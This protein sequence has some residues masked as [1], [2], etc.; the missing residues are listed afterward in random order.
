MAG[1]VLKQTS[2][3][4]VI[5]EMDSSDRGYISHL[6]LTDFNSLDSGVGTLAI[7]PASTSGLTLIGS[8]VDTK[9][10][11][12]VGNHDSDAAAITTVSTFNFY[13]NL[14]SV[15]EFITDAIRP[16]AL[17]NNVDANIKRMSDSE[18]N[19]G[20]IR[21]I[22]Q[23]IYEA[24]VGSY[25]LQPSAPTDGTWISKGTITNTLQGGSSNTSQLWRKSAPASTPTT[26]RP[27][28]YVVS[29]G[30]MREMTDTEIKKLTPRLRNRIVANG[31]GQYKLQNL[32]PDT[33]GTWIQAGAGF[34]DTRRQVTSQNYS[35]FFS[36]TFSGTFTNTFAGFF[37][38]TY[39]RF[40]SFSNTFL[41]SFA[42]SRTKFFTG[43][44][45]GFFTGT[46]TNTFAAPT[47][48]SSTE[49]VTER[50]LWV[51]TS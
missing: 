4:G 5:Q 44:F 40:A 15:S 37:S 46:F 31:I 6:V 18:L 23:D 41:G 14:G 28:K 16:L 29:S 2:S 17:D 43:S 49:N 21:D 32:A 38:A 26:V 34:V 27:M 13:Q 19:D 12:A 39:N 22:Q 45:T 25:V 48:Q 3:G 7:N 1:I 42:G 50:K 20:I 11:N 35:G 30:S 51:R 8:F 9:R 36:G 24:G 33:G 10:T 47:V